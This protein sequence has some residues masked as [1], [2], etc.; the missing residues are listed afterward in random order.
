MRIKLIVTAAVAAVMCLAAAG[1]LAQGQ[2][3]AKQYYLALGDSLARGA[4]PNPSGTTV[5]TNKGYA[6]DL[7]A[8]EK[9]SST[10]SRSSNSAASA[11]PPRR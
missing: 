7:R 2:A 5:P 10:T 3:T 9:R 1:A 4:Q 6:N 11:R 8:I